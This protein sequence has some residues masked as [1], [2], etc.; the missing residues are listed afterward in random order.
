MILK[1]DAAFKTSA[2][3]GFAIQR[4][5]ALRIFVQAKDQAQQRGFAAAAGADDADEF[6]RRNVELDVVEYC[7]CV[8]LPGREAKRLL[9]FSRVRL[10]LSMLRSF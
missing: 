4:G 2:F 1:H 3:D 8:E 5:C 10:L 9:M 6:A 7:N